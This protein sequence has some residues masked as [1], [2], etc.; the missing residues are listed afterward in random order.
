MQIGLVGKPSCGKSSFFKAATLIDVKIT[1]IPFCTIEPNVGIGYITTDC[2]CKK[3]GVKCNPQNSICKDGKRFIPVKL[4]D[5]AGLVP[6]AHEGRGLGNKFLDD[7]RQASVLIHIVDCSGTRDAE[8]KIT[9]NYDPSFD[10][11]F[12]EKEID[13]WFAGVIKRAIEKFARI[14]TSSKSD[15]IQVLTENLSG[16]GITKEHISLALEK[17]SIGNVERFA[18]V[19]RRISKPIVIAANKIDL[20]SSQE[21]FEK[22]KEKYKD[23]LIIPTSAEAEIALKK[24]SEKGL[25]E[26][27]PG[28]DFKILDQSRLDEEQRKGLETIKNEVIKK[29]GSAGVQECLNKAVF[30]VLDYIVVYPVADINKLSDKK[31]NVLPDAFLVK[32]GTTLKEF[33]FSI[34]SEIGERFIGGLEA[35]TKRKLGADYTLKNNDVIEIL[36]KR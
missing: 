27:L 5:V 16:L 4:I 24:A 34:H 18:N 21:N 36:F 14:S 12:L 29:Y 17:S 15:L 1:G 31:G 23:L 35:K 32:N 25:I 2:V 9:T 10:V 30:S 26:Y 33:A 6:G 20:K 8:G 11:E 7:L 22:L 19:I 3:Y 13:L 28:D